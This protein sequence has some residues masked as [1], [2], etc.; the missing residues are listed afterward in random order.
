MEE[1]LS[2]VRKRRPIVKPNKSF[3]KQLEVYEGILA[4][5]RHRH[6][7]FGLANAAA[8]FGGGSLG[9]GLYR[10]GKRAEGNEQPAFRRNR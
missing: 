1:T 10:D 8:Q 9:S 4:A 6:T 2:F 3:L 7:Y 5:I